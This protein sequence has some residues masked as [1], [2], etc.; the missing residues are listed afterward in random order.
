[1]TGPA[2]RTTEYGACHMWLFRHHPKTGV[3][4]FCDTTG[5]TDYALKRGRRY[6]RDRGDYHELCREC[7]G[8]YD[9]GGQRAEHA[10]LT[11]DQVREIRA[12]Y[13]PQ[14]GGRGRKNPNSQRGLAQ[15]YGVSPGTIQQIVEGRKWAWA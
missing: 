5:R 11:D 6:S 14:C 3:C 4:D 12:R 8:R 7:H 9:R 15:E 2:S 1:V 13:T 10:K